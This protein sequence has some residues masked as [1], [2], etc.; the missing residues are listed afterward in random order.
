MRK[1]LMK[2]VSKREIWEAVKR[3]DETGNLPGAK[4]LVQEI[5]Q[6]FGVEAIEVETPE[7]KIGWRK[8]KPP[9]E[10]WD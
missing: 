4:D 10:F 2:G 6:R 8:P 1:K 5:G 9:P 3:E 7:K